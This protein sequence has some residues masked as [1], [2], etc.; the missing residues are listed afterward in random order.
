MSTRSAFRQ[1][2]LDDAGTP[3]VDTTFCIIDVETTGG[4][5]RD[6][7]ITE[8]G[9][10]RLR[11]GVCEATFS[12]LVDPGMP[13]PSF[14]TE[15]TGIRTDMVD[16]A[17]PFRAVAAD[18]VE[19]VGD[20]V[21]V[22]HNVRYDLGFLGAELERS[23]HRRFENA[24][25]CT[26]A[27]AR[28]LVRAEVPNCRLGTLADA[29]RL[30]HRPSH[31]ALDD[32]LA[33]GDLLMVLLD[34]AGS[35]GVL[36]LDDLLDWPRLAGHPHI[37]KLRL[38]ESLPHAPGVY[39]FRDRVGNVLYV[40]KATDLRARVRSYFSS[41]DRRK[42]GD[43]LRSTTSIDHEVGVHPLAAAVREVRLIAEHLPRF[44]SHAT[45]WR[46]MAYVCLGH[47]PF[48]RLIVTRSPPPP[49]TVYLGPLPSAAA[50]HRAIEAITT[51]VP[52]RRCTTKVPESGLGQLELDGLGTPP[53]PAC[54]A[55]QLGVASCPC[56]GS[57][58][59]EEYA[60][61]CDTIRAG[62]AAHPE[63]LLDPLRSRIIELATGQHFERA[64]ELRDR[65]AT[66]ADA[67]H[68]RRRL[69][70]WRRP[71]RVVVELPDG[72]GAEIIHGMLG[73]CWE[74]GGR[75]AGPDRPSAVPGGPI[76]RE[77][78]YERLSI[79]TEVERIR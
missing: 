25:V 50:A 62:V 51:V 5:P 14:I 15:L 42:V 45:R 6:G 41:D 60:R 77:E 19:F 11:G 47:E 54:T 21:I 9:A 17:P 10:V 74:P 13:I 49:G 23:G 43:L 33:T 27:L 37:A 40:G 39:L 36:G 38:T 65:A 64:A 69:E 72:R 57:I 78:V 32:A 31:R 1:R 12:S 30:D 35:H 44:N 20:A 18:L 71:A 61:L 63:V 76:P 16:G 67:I 2:S 68:R 4:T 46:S 55:A 3:L 73:R 56:S 28:R 79:G 52:L 7:A 75:P 66:L 29:L 70:A 53:R 22:G 24:S 8:I 34:R 26:L 58:S 59:R 48:P